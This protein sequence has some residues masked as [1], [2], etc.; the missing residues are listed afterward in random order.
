VGGTAGAAE[1]ARA[2][3]PARAATRLAI[4]VCI[5][6]QVYSVQVGSVPGRGRSSARSPGS[7]NPNLR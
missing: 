3:D 5:S 7:S 4:D 1:A 6:S 2:I